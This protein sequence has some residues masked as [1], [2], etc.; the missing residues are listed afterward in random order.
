MEAADRAVE[1]G[2][3]PMGKKL[4]WEAEGATAAEADEALCRPM[5]R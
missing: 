5:S 3:K 2:G 1:V 4:L